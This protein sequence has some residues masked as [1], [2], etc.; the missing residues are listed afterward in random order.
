M[1]FL[2]ALFAALNFAF[3]GS[4]TELIK[5]L[6]TDPN[7]NKTAHFAGEMK[8]RK[9]SV[10]KDVTLKGVSSLGIGESQDE[11]DEYKVIRASIEQ[12]DDWFD[13]YFFVKDE[14]IYAVRVLALMQIPKQIA[15]SYDRA[16]EADR[17]IIDIGQI[18][19][20]IARD[21]ELVAFGRQN[22]DKF[23]TIFQAKSAGEGAK[24]EQI[25]S[26]LH[27]TSAEF[28]NEIFIL[29]IGG[30]TDNTVGFMRADEPSK[31]PKMSPHEYIMIEQISPKWYLFKTT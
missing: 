30:V 2:L 5:Q 27:F 24:A 17:R 12:K 13:L 9:F 6:F 28:Q 21:S 26:E 20:M 10:G 19:L 15:R 4:N 8:E 11:S 29:T 3:A 7:F 25:L 23:E 16:S 22:L 1:K 14:K 18:R 31:L